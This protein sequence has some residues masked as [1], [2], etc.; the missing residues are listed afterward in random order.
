MHGVSRLCVGAWIS[1][2][3]LTVEKTLENSLFGTFIRPKDQTY[4][5]D[6]KEKL[7]VTGVK[8]VG[9]IPMMITHRIFKQVPCRL[10]RGDSAFS[11]LS[12]S[13]CLER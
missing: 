3:D 9:S 6:V 4:K 13:V 7:T 2:T 12:I 1:G 5:Y 10:K 11:A 8:K